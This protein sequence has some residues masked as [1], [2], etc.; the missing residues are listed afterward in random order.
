MAAKEK[1]TTPVTEE[2]P[3]RKIRKE[4]LK[5]KKKK[6]RKPKARKTRKARLVI[7]RVK[8]SR[9]VLKAQ[10]L[11]RTSLKSAMKGMAIRRVPEKIIKK[12]DISIAKSA[13]F[14]AMIESA[15][16]AAVNTLPA[17]TPVVKAEK[18]K[19]KRVKAEKTT[20]LRKKAR[21]KR[22]KKEK[23]AV[24]ATPEVPAA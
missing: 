24:E 23:V 19:T 4:S 11:A 1:S 2:K 17:P 22:V 14:A 3:T 16:V 6:V 18:V 7:K 21:V 12:I 5:E 10:V 13:E 20:K 8:L 9:L 15:V